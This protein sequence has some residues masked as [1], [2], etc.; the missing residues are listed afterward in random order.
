MKLKRLKF[1]DVGEKFELEWWRGFGAGGLLNIKTVL[2]A[3]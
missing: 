2:E 1:N 3:G